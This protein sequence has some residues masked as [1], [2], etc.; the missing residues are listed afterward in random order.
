MATKVNPNAKQEIDAYIESMPAFSKAICKKLRAIILKAEPSLQ[1]DWK[2]G[3]HYSSNGMVCGFSGFQKH[4]KLTFF[5]GAGM[6]DPNKLFNHCVDNEFS[7][8]VKYTDVKE[9]DEKTLTEYVRESVAVN[10]KGFKRE[11]KNK[12]VEV[13]ADLQQSL[14]KNKTASSFFNELSYVYKKDFVEWVTSA[15]REETRKDRIAKVFAMCKEKRRM[16]DQYK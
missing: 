14:D 6:K 3:P 4:A 5:N 11:T 2:W 9:I 13:P 15:R 7:R 8:S 12:T 10:A 16:N 1:E